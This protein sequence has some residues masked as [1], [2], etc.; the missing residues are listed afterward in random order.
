MYGGGGKG[1][2]F[3][4]DPEE[5]SA[6]IGQWE[7]VLDKI[8]EDGHKIRQPRRRGERYGARQGSGQRKLRLDQSG[9]SIAALLNQNDSMRKYAQEYIKKLKEA[10]SKTVVTDQ[11]L[12]EHLQGL[13][14]RT[15]FRSKLGVLGGVRGRFR[16]G[17]R[18]RAPTTGGTASPSTAGSAARARRRRIPEV[19]K[20]CRPL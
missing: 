12:S 18:P 3:K 20:V 16:P 6:V 8:V 15:L 2:Q 5:L 10:Q 17:S 14:E 1:G 9:D 4:M 13:G 7:D 11:D 19:P